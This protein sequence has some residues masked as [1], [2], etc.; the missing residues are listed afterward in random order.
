MR[1]VHE[2][3]AAECWLG[4]APPHL[5]SI[6]RF[7]QVLMAR[8]N[9]K[10]MLAFLAVAQE[11]SFTRAA[12]RLGISQSALSHTIRELEAR[13]GV[14]L[15]SRTTRS[16]SPT[17]AGERLMQTVGP[18]LEE[19]EAEIA[20]VSELGDKPV[21]TIRITAIDHV[22]DTVLWPRL[23]PVLEQY[24]D[25][26][27]ELS[28]DYRFV[29]I[30]AER[31][32]IGVRYGDQLQQDMVAVRMT[33]DIPMSIVAAPRYFETHRVPVTVQDLLRHN[34]ITLRLSSSGRIYAWELLDAHGGGKP[35]EVSVS[36]QVIFTGA[37]QMLH[38]A[39]SG[40]GLAFLPADLTQPHVDAGR[41]VRMMDDCC[42]SFAGLHA[43]YPSHRNSSRAMQLV[44]E[45]IRFRR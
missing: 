19:I 23:A 40:Y 16:V 8:D 11:R 1:Q 7:F 3:R 17:E 37:Y 14:R 29:D 27:V 21:G 20:A 35:V 30:A 10:D 22:I 28:T 2:W 45:A 18:R 43:Y 15:L 31:F 38:A 5:E 36:G 33:E 25:V 12:A 4:F 6:D 39:L 13:L 9:I 42:P 26:R 24:P 44:I 34:C 32:D 41:L